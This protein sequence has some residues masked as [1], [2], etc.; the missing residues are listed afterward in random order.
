MALAVVFGQRRCDR[1]VTHGRHRF[2]DRPHGLLQR[3][4]LGDLSHH[5]RVGLGR[6]DLGGVELA[7]E[8]GA[9]LGQRVRCGLVVHGS[10]G[11]G[12]SAEGLE[13][14]APVDSS[15]VGR[16]SLGSRFPSRSSS[17]RRP[18]AMRDFT[19]P[20]GTDSASAISA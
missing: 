12:G 11:G 5:R 6:G 19:V 16:S 15:L 3:A 20:I 17:I 4:Q 14:S 13:P 7:V 2:G 1:T 8:V 10:L 9:G 18:R